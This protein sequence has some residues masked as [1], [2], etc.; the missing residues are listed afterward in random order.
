[1][2]D[3][4]DSGNL[5]C[6]VNST[7]H[8]LPQSLVVQKRSMFCQRGDPDQRDEQHLVTPLKVVAPVQPRFAQF[9]F[10]RRIAAFREPLASKSKRRGHASE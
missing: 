5:G 10:S 9:L 7:M 3:S 8:H 6:R 1:M 2:P 4:S